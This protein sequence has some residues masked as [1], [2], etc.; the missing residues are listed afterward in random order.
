M[1][2]FEQLEVYQLALDYVDHV[3][4]LAD[5]LPHNEAFNLNS[6]TT[7]AATSIALNIAEGS[8]G[9]SN[10]EQCRFLAMSIRSLLE[11]IACQHIIQRRGY[12]PKDDPLLQQLDNTGQILA[13]K[14]QA[15]R[16][17]LTVEKE[18]Q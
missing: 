8:T 4:K 10:A 11:T 16:K 15:M 12:L 1:Y 2:K 9:Q 13:R 7:R 17:S 6:Q 3:Y 5:R 18:H 14:L